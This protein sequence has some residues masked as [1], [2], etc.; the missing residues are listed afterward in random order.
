MSKN[1]VSTLLSKFR[2]LSCICVVLL[3]VFFTSS[4]AAAATLT[5]SDNLVLRDVDDKAIEQGFLS[6]QQTIELSKG[7]HTLVLKYKD[8]FEDLDFAEDK[9]IKSDYFVVKFSLEDH[10]ILF[11]TTSKIN[12]LAAAERFAKSPE[13]I[14]LDDDKKEL[15]LELDKLSDYELGKQVTKVVTALSVPAD[16]SANNPQISVT[17]QND[18]NFNDKVM[19]EVDALPML[20]F[21]WEKANKVQQ[22]KFL[23]FV[24]EKKHLNK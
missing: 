1:F 12:D 23:Q 5:L 15:I 17:T 8:V 16:T 24:N 21:W 13:L 6:K 19:S 20:K 22:T 14:L 7:K 2:L 18:M 11:L 3:A 9:L 4:K 10:Q